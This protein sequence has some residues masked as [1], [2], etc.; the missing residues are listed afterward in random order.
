QLATDREGQHEN[1]TP[2]ELAERRIV[3]GL[4]PDE[5]REVQE[6]DRCREPPEDQRDE[7]ERQEPAAGARR[8]GVGGHRGGGHGATVAAGRSRLADSRRA[9]APREPSTPPTPNPAPDADAFHDRAPRTRSWNET[10]LRGAAR[11]AS[12]TAPPGPRRRHLLR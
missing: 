9:A 6:H 3:A 5:R 8:S 2:V 10:E 11:Q 12:Q 4:W 1:A 7:A